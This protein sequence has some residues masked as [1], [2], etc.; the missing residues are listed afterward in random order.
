M[1]LFPLRT[2]QL[3][4][5]PHR[6]HRHGWRSPCS[7]KCKCVRAAAVPVWATNSS[8]ITGHGRPSLLFLF[9][10]QVFPRSQVMA[11]HHCCS[12]LGNKFFQDGMPSLL[13]LFRQQVLPRS[14]ALGGHQVRQGAVWNLPGGLHGPSCPSGCP[15]SAL[16]ALRLPEGVLFNSCLSEA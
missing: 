3:T 13:F 6:C 9:R 10:Q 16:H 11:C 5:R 4:L 8:K 2:C 15:G 1:I 7:R 12:C 14:Q